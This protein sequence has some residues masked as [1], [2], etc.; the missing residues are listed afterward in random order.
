M[1][2]SQT[3][4]RRQVLAASVA[5]TLGLGLDARRARAQPRPAPP[6]I[7]FMLADDL[8]Y[9]D[10]SCYGR[11]F[12]TPRIDSLARH[13][14]LFTQAYASSAVCSATRVALITGR[15]PGRLRVG[16]DEP[17][18]FDH[19][20]TIGL[21][22]GHPHAAVAAAQAGV[23]HL[24]V[25]QV[26]PGQAAEVRPDEERLRPL[27]R[28]VR[29]LLVLLRPRQGRPE[30]H[31]RRRAHPHRPRLSHRSARLRR[32]SRSWKPARANRAPC[33]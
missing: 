8:G 16:L 4:T 12:S 23:S 13:G 11:N 18:A 20:A 5:G 31:H 27:L 2:P 17:L 9:A 15:E 33:S 26:A 3:L 30:P 22:A 21:P 19:E 14:A 7:V 29:R 28:H 32:P 24:A 25:R 1:S 6:N 10:L